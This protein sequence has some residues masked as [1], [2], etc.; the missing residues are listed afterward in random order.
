MN[1]SKTLKRFE[2]EGVSQGHEIRNIVQGFSSWKLFDAI[3]VTNH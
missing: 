2:T 3:L 1:F